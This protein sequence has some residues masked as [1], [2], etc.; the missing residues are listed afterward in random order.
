M[1][2]LSSNTKDFPWSNDIL[3]QW[4]SNFVLAFKLRF[5]V[6]TLSRSILLFH[7]EVSFSLYLW[8]VPL[9]LINRTFWDLN[10]RRF[11]NASV[12]ITTTKAW[13]CVKLA[14]FANI[15]NLLIHI[16]IIYSVTQTVTKKNFHVSQF[17]LL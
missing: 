15:L 11:C 3:H 14:M 5:P 9:N 8:F 13:S 2:I 12:T 6:A 7:E 4:S 1:L 10:L 17:F 16:P